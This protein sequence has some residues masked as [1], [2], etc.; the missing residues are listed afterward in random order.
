LRKLY[1]F[2]PSLPFFNN[3]LQGRK[4]RCIVHLPK[5]LNRKNPSIILGRLVQKN[6][7]FPASLALV[8]VRELGPELPVEF[9]GTEPAVEKE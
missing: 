8:K 3:A 5:W 4:M 2:A 1:A 9:P 7:D 6:N